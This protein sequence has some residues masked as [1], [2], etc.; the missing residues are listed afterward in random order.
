MALEHVWH[1]CQCYE[2]GCMFCDGG[3]GLCT[4]CGAFEGQLLTHCPG[5][6]LS[7]ETLEACYRGNVKDLAAFR[8]GVQHGA[9]IVDGRLVWRSG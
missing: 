8:V 9:R 4:V 3:L 1:K 2:A 7:E 6:R 5:Y